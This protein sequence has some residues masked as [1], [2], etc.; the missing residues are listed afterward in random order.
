MHTVWYSLHPI[1]GAFASY[2]FG[3]SRGDQLEPGLRVGSKMGEFWA[4]SFGPI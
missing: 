1:K 2:D 4:Q 3:M